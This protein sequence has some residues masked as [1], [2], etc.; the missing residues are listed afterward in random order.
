VAVVAA[1]GEVLLEIVVALET[2][3]IQERLAQLIV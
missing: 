2:Q 3:E 1:A